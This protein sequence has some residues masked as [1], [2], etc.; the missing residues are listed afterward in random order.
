MSAPT[1]SVAL[2]VW[3]AMLATPVLFA[4]VTVAAA[5]PHGMRS[6]ELAG[7]FLWMSAAVVGLGVALSHLLPRRIRQHEHGSRDAVAFTRL[8]LAWALLEGAAMFPL[9]AELVTGD[10]LLYLLSAAAVAAQ[11]SLFPSEARWKGFSVQPLP[12]GGPGQRIRP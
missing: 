3:G 7:M 5:P 4:G 12:S 8:V 2:A 9:V 1:R 6:P 11:L 10:P